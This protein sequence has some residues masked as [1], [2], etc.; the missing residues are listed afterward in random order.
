MREVKVGKHKVVLYNSIEELPMARF[1]KYNKMML[2]DA[3]LGS[4]LNAVDGHIERAVAFIRNDRRQEAATEL[5][6]MRQAIYL[7]MQQVSPRHLSFAVLVKSVDGMTCDDI[8][9]EGLQRVV[10]MLA[11]VPVGDMTAEGEAVKKK[12]D[13]E[14]NIYFPDVFDNVMEKEYY[15]LMKR[16]TQAMLDA[17]LNGDTEEQREV[18]GRLTDELVMFSKP[19]SFTGKDSAEVAY[20]KQYE[21]MCLTMSQQLH[22]D[23]K[24]Y[25]VMEYYNAYGY[26][27]KQ[28][29]RQKR[30]K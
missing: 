1:H 30:A 3:G 13:N 12:I 8:S 25:T 24:K 4:D 19:R 21:D 18:I 17:V 20:D 9:D 26:I 10:D 5:E 2:V 16:R 29:K 11:D 15:D 7:V 14:L 23:P 22:Q 27:K 28:L 6:N